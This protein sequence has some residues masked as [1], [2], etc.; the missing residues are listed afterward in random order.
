MSTCCLWNENQTT[1]K[2]CPQF[3]SHFA[4]AHHQ[5]KQM[6]GK[7]AATAG[8]HSANAAVDQTEDQM[9]E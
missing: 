6:Q 5:Y 8:Y 3:K 9:A 2:T 4:A 7:S 1:N